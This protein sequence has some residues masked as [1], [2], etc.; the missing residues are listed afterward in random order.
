MT[1]PGLVEAQR[2]YARRGVA[3]VSLTN[4]PRGTAERFANDFSIPWP[5]G[6]GA[7]MQF[8]ARLGTYNAKRMSASYTPNFAINPTVFLIDPEGRVLWNDAQARPLHTQET[9]AQVRDI[10]TAIERALAVVSSPH[11][12]SSHPV[13]G[14][15]V[16]RSLPSK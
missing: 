1:A 7:S 10:D 11:R 13:A 4:E 9:M 16:P 6:Y 8:L 5:S 12:S 3:F 2:K 14:R 15:E